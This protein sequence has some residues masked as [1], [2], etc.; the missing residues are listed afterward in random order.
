MGSQAGGEG[1]FV[2][3]KNLAATLVAMSHSRLELIGNEIEAEKLRALRILLLMQALVFCVGLGV[4]LALVLIALLLWDQR[5][6]VIAVFA[7]IFI[8]SA[9]F[10]YAA[11]RRTLR[12]PEPVFVASLAELQEDLRQLKATSG[13]GSTP[14]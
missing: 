5:V 3:L 10:L 9:G 4:L 14:D 8:G 7:V 1:L 2:S 13:H 11:L 6:T 12:R